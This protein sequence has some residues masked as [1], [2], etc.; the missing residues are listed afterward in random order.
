MPALTCV[1]IPRPR[2]A[3]QLN[4][5]GMMKLDNVHSSSKINSV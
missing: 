5:D 4:N 1:E 2:D 3:T